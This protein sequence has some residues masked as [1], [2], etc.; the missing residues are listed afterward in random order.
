MG[1]DA[2]AGKAKDAVTAGADS[3]ESAI[4]DAANKATQVTRKAK[5]AATELI[6][7]HRD[8]VADALQSATETIRARPITSV[9][10]VAAVAYLW[11]RLS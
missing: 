3:V 6:D 7:E 10:V 9:A 5:D 2:T 1:A 4:N 11:G 8:A